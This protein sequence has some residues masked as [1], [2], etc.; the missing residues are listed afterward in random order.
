MNKVKKYTYYKIIQ[1]N[2][3]EGWNDEDFH[4]CDS[5][6]NALD[7]KALKENLKEYKANGCGV[8]RVIKRKELA[9]SNIID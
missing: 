2:Y 7:L 8:Y 1:G 3:G 5:S 4:E 6:Y 9:C